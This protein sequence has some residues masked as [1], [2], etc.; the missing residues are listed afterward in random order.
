[1]ASQVL[2]IYGDR[3]S[4]P[5]R[6]LLLFSKLNG[7]EFEEV[8]IDLFSGASKTPEF[9]GILFFSCIYMYPLAY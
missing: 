7:I 5:T 6:A 9:E 3:K 1:M 4:Q 2:K 8:T